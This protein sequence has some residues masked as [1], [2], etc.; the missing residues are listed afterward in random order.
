MPRL[1]AGGQNCVSA[2]KNTVPNSGLRGQALRG[3]GWVAVEKWGV[4]L[5]SLAVFVILV[6]TI[7]AEAFG[8]VSFTTSVSAL[9]LVFVDAGFP[10]SLIQRKS[11]GDHDAD[12]AFW[13]SAVI[14]VVL[15]VVLF[16]VAP[17]IES[18]V[19]LVGLSPVLRVLSLS[20]FATALS[21]V[22]SALL[23]R[24][25]NFKALGVR[26]LIGTVVG[27]AIAVP[28]AVM[29]LGV[30]ALVAQSLGTLTASTIALWIASPW[31]P[32]FR[33]SI[34][35]LRE[36][37][38]FGLSVMGIQLMNALQANIDKILVNS[39]LGA[40]AGGIYFVAQRA[41]NLVSE[42]ITT[43]I[44]KIALTTFSKMQDDKKRLN[45]AFIQLTFATCVVAFPVFAVAFA[46]ADIILPFIAGEEAHWEQAI[47]LM[48]I[49]AVSSAFTAVAYYDKQA[50][51]SVGHP[52]KAFALGVVENLF[53][54]ALFVA[55]APLGLVALAVTRAARL[56][57]MW[58]VRLWLL[59]RFAGISVTQ[60]ISN[61][62]ISLLAVAPALGM[63]Y[64]LATTPWRHADHLF[65][66]Y[67][68]PVA[69]IM[70]VAYGC[71]LLL[72]CGRARRNLI[73][74][75]LTYVRKR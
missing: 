7:D 35:T 3:I 37:T 61:V 54:I 2:S 57:V 21:S 8:L 67:G 49:F 53:G 15:Y 63:A 24:D 56:F 1:H 68:V 52:K 60:Y 6:R 36:M 59:N 4:R 62:G 51:L 13:T 69:V 65:W 39:L 44:G 72:C 25:M 45:R 70:F 33:F 58:P 43:V 55:A 26:N 22:P 18:T 66:S 19:G 42:L 71:A 17:L 14:A 5:M 40:Q 10:K 30:W 34:V 47:P 48:Q 29:G 75:T 31:K 12:T 74:T 11:L 46:L 20:L 28:M 64:L 32:K 73:L 27:A 23:E 16:F 41:V 38:S 50:L 9:L